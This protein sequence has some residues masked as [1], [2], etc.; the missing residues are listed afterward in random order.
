MDGYAPP[1]SPNRRSV[2]DARR[3]Q[4]SLSQP[5]LL[6]PSSGERTMGGERTLGAGAVLWG[7][8]HGVP[9]LHWPGAWIDT[10]ITDLTDP[11]SST[12]QSPRHV[13]QGRLPS[14]SL[15]ARRAQ[16]VS[17][18]HH[19]SSGSSSSYP[20]QPKMVNLRLQ[21]RLAASVLKTGKRKVWLDPNETAEISMANSRQNIRKVGVG[22][23]ACL[24]ERVTR[25]VCFAWG[26]WMGGLNGVG[27]GGGCV[28]AVWVCVCCVWVWWARAGWGRRRPR[29]D[30]SIDRSDG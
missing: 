27:V 11:S 2:T 30:R 21:K 9:A 7:H 24:L 17:G 8:S 29:V 23:R 1:F 18:Q 13:V 6:L 16:Q 10:T 19:R 4:R 22:P 14:L 3:P 5:S 28:C 20:T 15:E 25:A 12:I 26:R